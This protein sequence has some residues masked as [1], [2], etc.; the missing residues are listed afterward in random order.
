MP[1]RPRSRSRRGR[2]C[3]AARRARCRLRHADKRSITRRCRCGLVSNWRRLRECVVPRLS[4]LMRE[5]ADIAAVG[6]LPRDPVLAGL[7]LDSR[8]VKPGYLFAALAGARADGAGFVAEAVKRGAV[9]ILV[10]PDA[11]LPPLGPEIAIVRDANPRRRIARMA[12]A[13]AGLQPDTIVAVT[14]TNGKSS[15]VHFV[16]H[17]WAT[18]GLKAA[19]VGT[20]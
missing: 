14:G 11:V 4:D 7:T 16:R 2:S 9:A 19:S 3:P 15:T 8:K 17:I 10:A 1:G 20:L 5:S 18:L 13:F 12:A 6:A